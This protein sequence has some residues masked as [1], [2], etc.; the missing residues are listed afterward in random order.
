MKI[1]LNN[2]V[3]KDTQATTDKQKM[4]GFSYTQ[5]VS[6]VC[7]LDVSEKANC[8]ARPWLT[9][10]LLNDFPDDVQCCNVQCTLT[11]FS[12]Y[13]THEHQSLDLTM[14]CKAG[15]NTKL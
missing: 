14:E 4:T 6:C 7:V 9:R 2:D 5:D 12:V 11:Q 8:S 10:H 3:L 15:V 1:A 13:G